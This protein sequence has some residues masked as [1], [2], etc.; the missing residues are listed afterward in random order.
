MQRCAAPRVIARVGAVAA[1]SFSQRRR[2]RQRIAGELRPGGVGQELPLPAH[3]HRENPG[4]DRRDDQGEQ[5][6]HQHDQAE[7]VAAALAA[8]AA[9]TAATAAPPGCRPAASGPSRPTSARSR[10]PSRPAASSAGCRGSAMWAI[11]CATTPAARPGRAPRAAL[12]SPRCWPSRRRGRWRTR[13]DRG[14]ARSRPWASGSPEAIAIS[15]TTFTSC[16]AP[17]W[18]ARRSPTRRWTRAPAGRRSARSTSRSPPATRVVKMP[19]KGIDVMVGLGRR[20]RR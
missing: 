12:R 11:S 3:R 1:S 7:R 5:P 20:R 10:P 6:E 17:A 8:S 4:H 9:A 19:M 14:R 18:R 16:A 15:S 13:W 2:E